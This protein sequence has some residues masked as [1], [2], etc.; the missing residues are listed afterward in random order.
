MKDG[1]RGFDYEEKT[2][3]AVLGY[4]V[5]HLPFKMGC[6][7]CGQAHTPGTRAILNYASYST[8]VHT[9][10]RDLACQVHTICFCRQADHMWQ[11][12]VGDL[13][14]LMGFSCPVIGIWPCPPTFTIKSYEE[15]LI[16]RDRRHHVCT[17]SFSGL[18]D[19]PFAV[20]VERK[21]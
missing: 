4:V 8:S 11:T 6:M 18:M 12:N 15:P 1:H 13:V 21:I 19:R 16:W 17:W 10:K 3:A 2:D 9:K 14:K 5:R 7:I 20:I